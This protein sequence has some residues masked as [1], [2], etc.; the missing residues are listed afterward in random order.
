MIYCLNTLDPNSL[1]RIANS[2]ATIYREIRSVEID[3][4][5][6]QSELAVV[7]EN[8]NHLK[9]RAAA[10]SDGTLRILAMAVI[11]EDKF[12]GTVAFEEPEN[13]IDPAKLA[14]LVKILRDIAVDSS[15]PVAADNPL[16]NVIFTTHSPSIIQMLK[17][18]EIQ[19]AQPALGA[20]GRCK[21][22]RLVGE[23]S[24]QLSWN[25]VLQTLEPPD[26]ETEQAL[27]KPCMRLG[28]RS[29]RASGG[30]S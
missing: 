19:W 17:P 22:L 9:I 27:G 23:P 3:V 5:A 12:E 1:T 2:V 13:G 21:F 7:V 16:R 11:L 24:R 20:R 29:N 30:P 10:L 14:G 4:D 25:T 18:E 6:A 28:A 26:T 15:M 8:L